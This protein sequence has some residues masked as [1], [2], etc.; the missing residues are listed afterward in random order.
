M[1]KKKAQNK[2]VQQTRKRRSSVAAQKQK[3]EWLFPLE[4]R[5]FI[6]IGIG[7]VIILVAYGLMWTGI[8]DQPALPDGQWNNPF[9]VTIAPILL[10][11]GYC[12]V[13]PY[14]IISFSKRSKAA[15]EDAKVASEDAKA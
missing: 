7:L 14:A 9:A 4:K 1:A 8:S 12:V 15:S 13:I 3:V 11:I 5:N 6:I 10:V 2:Q